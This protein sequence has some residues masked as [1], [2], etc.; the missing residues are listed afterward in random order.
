MDYKTLPLSRNTIKW[1]APLVRKQF[2][3]PESGYFDVVSAFELL[4]AMWKDV[5]TE[6]VADEMLPDTMPAE[7]IP[8]LNG[9]YYIRVKERVYEG[10]CDGIGGYRA[11]ILHEM[12]HV[13]LCKL[14]F[15][16]ILGRSFRNGELD[17]FE[18]MEWQAKALCGEVLIPYNEIDDKTISQIMHD[19]GVS[20]SCATFCVKN[21]KK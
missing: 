10:A 8:D 17:A 6:I 1:L 4:P 16:P 7:C 21:F 20:C 9:N 13:I 11:H 2:G 14:G 19:Y 15:T 18:S 5:T 3:Q 12:C